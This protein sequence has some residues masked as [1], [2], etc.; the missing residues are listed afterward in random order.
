[1]SA[2]KKGIKALTYCDSYKYLISC[3]FDFTILI[4]N[5]YLDHP[6]AKLTGHESPIVT[7]L[8][9]TYYNNL[10]FSCDSYGLLKIWNAKNFTLILSIN[11]VEVNNIE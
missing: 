6:L 3:S 1:M 5:T 8:S 7:V 4:W 2:H 9:P 11:A 10:I